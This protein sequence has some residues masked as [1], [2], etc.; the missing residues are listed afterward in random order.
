MINRAPTKPLNSYD[1]W[2]ALTEV[3]VGSATNYLS[4]DRELSFDLFF[5]ENLYRS[6]WAYP[7]L[8]AIKKGER[9]HKIALTRVDE[10]N[11]DVEGFAG[12]LSSLGISVIRP[13]SLPPCPNTIAGL[14]WEARATPAL[15]IRDNT[16]ILGDEI[17]ETAPA[18]RSRYLETRLLSHH[19]IHYF[20]NGAK[21]ATMPRPV[22][23][24]MSF[25]LSYASDPATTLGGPTEPIYAPRASA[26]DVGV[27][28]M[29]DGAQCL[30][31]GQ[32]IVVNIAQ[33]NHSMAVDWLEAHLRGR[34]RV[35]RVYR[36]SDNHIDSM[37]LALRPGVFLTRHAGVRE[38]MPEAFRSWK[39][40]VPPEP[41]NSDFPTYN[42][43]D[44][45][46]TSPYIDLNV[47]SLDEKRV[48]VN[49]DCGGLLQ[50]LEREGFDPIPIRHRHRRLFGGGFHCFTLDTVREG[51]LTD[52]R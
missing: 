37:I 7:R 41:K 30:R 52:Y 49:K 11:E 51:R 20:R 23:T 32:D 9:A 22:L 6:D 21:W 33:S 14:G 10:L 29:L 43:E 50:M 25:D 18:V 15:N 2:S 28:M 5:Y 24:D 44:I 34:F 36:L 3:I 31:L 35:H 13:L 27:E 38:M 48:C 19:Y 47:L 39:Y 1:D 12:L 26:F 46:L 16:L 17:I 45:V 40:I 42:D 4:H 8:S